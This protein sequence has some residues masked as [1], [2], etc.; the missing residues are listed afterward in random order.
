[1]NNKEFIS[2]SVRQARRDRLFKDKYFVRPSDLA[3]RR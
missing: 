2:T 3:A 1:M